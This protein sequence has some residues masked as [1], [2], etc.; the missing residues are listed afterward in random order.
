MKKSSV[1]DYQEYRSYLR[2]SLA[3]RS[4]VEKGQRLKL[5]KYLKCHPAYLT[6]ILDG[7]ADLSAEQG[8]NVNEFLGHTANESKY[9]LNL[10][11]M[12]RAGTAT[13]KSYFRE[14]LSRIRNEHRQLSSRIQN[15]RTLSET[16]QAKYYSSW[17]FAAIHVAA[18]LQNIRTREGIAKALSL[19]LPTVAAGL[20]FLVQI[21]IL[22]QH[23]NHFQQGEVRLHLGTDSPFVNKHHTN[24]RIKA[25]QSLDNKNDTDMHY[26]G[27]IT[28]SHQDIEKIREVMLSAIQEIKALIRES[29]D[30]TL[31]VYSLDLFG[32]LNTPPIG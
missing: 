12:E 16:D 28:C 27:V 15:H 1:F 17:H 32:L 2:N 26:S 19:P 9:F 6:R 24:W 7:R 31:F 13:L 4:H 3:S 21:G 30:E 20:E 5:S 29:Q 14:E 8:Q 25:I 18:S 10:V 11:L 23:G 22:R